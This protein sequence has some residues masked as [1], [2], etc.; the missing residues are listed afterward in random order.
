[1][2]ASKSDA[3]SKRVLFATDLSARC[4]RA[5]DRAELLAVELEARLT[6]VHAVEPD[7]LALTRKRENVFSWRRDPDRRVGIAK[8]QIQED[9][10]G[11]DTPFELVVEEGSPNDVILR[12]AGQLPSE[13][14]VTGIAR[15][16]TLGRS[17]FGA[18]VEHLIR[19]AAIPV[20]IV[21]TRPR[22]SYKN[23]VVATD[24]STA[25]RTALTRSM[26]MFPE[27]I[28][29]LL[30]CYRAA[31]GPLL[32]S[33]TADSGG[34]QIALG[35]YETFLEASGGARASI[36]ALPILMEPG[37]VDFVV[38]NYALDRGLD[39]L[40]IGS[41]GRNAVGRAI[42]GSTAELMLLTA[43]CDVLVTPGSAT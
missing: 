37:S 31:P 9:L 6:I 36:A 1:M 19:R 12:A 32:D 42:F 40:V 14:I 30:H 17:I 21:K 13:I 27:G 34:R 8:R 10:S 39:L 11:R 26:E 43:P 2:N 41:Q 38:Q 20:L 24:F 7:A 33:G 16:E 3:G 28:I 18:T 15:N 4:D 29:T 22:R 25:S 5:L 35:D 23:I